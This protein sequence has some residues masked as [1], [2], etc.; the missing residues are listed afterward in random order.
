MK[1]LKIMFIIMLVISIMLTGCKNS[2]KEPVKE[3]DIKQDSEVGEDKNTNDENTDDINEKEVMDEFL[4]MIN[5]DTNAADLGNYIRNHIKDVNQYDVEKM[6]E[7]LV[8]YQTELIDDFNKNTY[9]SGYMEALNEDMGGVLDKTKVGNISNEA[10]RREY[11]K[12][13]DGFLTIIRYEETPVVETNWSE[14]NSYSSNVSENFGKMMEL[15]KRIQNY[16]YKREELDVIG[17]TEDIIKA[18]DILG[19]KNSEF[20]ENKVKELYFLQIYA[21]LVGPEGSYLYFWID[22]DTKEYKDI[23]E[24]KEKYP[25]SK[26]SEII[27]DIDKAEIESIM[28]VIDIIDKKIQ[29]GLNS[30]NYLT[31]VNFKEDNGEYSIIQMIMPDNEEKQNSINYIIKK[32]IEQYVKSINI[33]KEFTLKIFRIFEDEQYISYTGFL[34][35]YD[36]QGNS[37]GISFYRTLDYLQEKILTLEDY[38]GKDFNTIRDDLEKISG[39]KVETMPDFILVNNGMELFLNKSDKIDDWIHL[40]SKDLVPYYE[41]INR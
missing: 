15:F 11:Q 33:N 28:D 40:N 4:E 38:L 1:Y 34:D 13:I 16:E 31:T 27:S 29:F 6:I 23:I 20:I 10:I 12:L 17:I 32:D 36:S 14:L 21:L 3:E 37:K 39:K 22:K 19:N 24:I 30:N 7:W 5:L 18:E 2:G 25:N 41:K 35:Y 9:E 26:L 8:I